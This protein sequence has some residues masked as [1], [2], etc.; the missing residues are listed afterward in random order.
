[1]CHSEV[2]TMSEKQAK[3]KYTSIPHFRGVI[4][5]V[6]NEKKSMVEKANKTTQKVSPQL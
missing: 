2:K 6:A 1:M 5:L 3:E 4:P